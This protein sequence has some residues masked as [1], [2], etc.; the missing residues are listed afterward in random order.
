MGLSTTMPQI[1]AESHRGPTLMKVPSYLQPELEGWCS[2]A[3]VAPSIPD[4][5]NT[6]TALWDFLSNLLCLS[7]I[8]AFA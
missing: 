2:R 7:C 5:Q 3:A 4:N 8:F 6:L 1:H